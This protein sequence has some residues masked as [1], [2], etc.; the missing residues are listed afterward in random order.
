MNEL[1]RNRIIN[2][3]SHAG[4]DYQK[5]HFLRD[6]IGGTNTSYFAEYDGVPYVLRI[7]ANDSSILSIDRK[8]E[9]AAVTIASR[10]RI[11][12]RLVCF[13][14]TNGDMITFLENGKIPTEKELQETSNLIM[15]AKM[16]KGLHRN[17]IYHVFDPFADI[18]IR[19]KYLYVE[20]KKWILN[21]DLFS[22]AIHIYDEIKKHSP[23]GINSEC[24]YGLC[25]NDPCIFNII[26]GEQLLFI[27]Y[28]FAGM[29]NVF[30][31]LASLG[32]LWKKDNQVALLEA[33]FGCYNDHHYK[34]FQY[35][36]LIQLIW[37]ATWGYVKHFSD[38]IVA[39]DYIKWSN[40]QLQLAISLDNSEVI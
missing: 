15:L 10:N 4:W 28:E 16:L 38:T 17:S 31:D 18:Q 27:D 1:H 35:Y 39:I 36:T 8:A 26:L 13:D 19:L 34:Y 3:V 23:D 22:Q 20:E 5:I 6:P 37:N 9:Y 14:E 30:F 33:Y 32:G 11:G 12:A 29:G 2:L 21:N 25:H 7:A 40:E 24:Y